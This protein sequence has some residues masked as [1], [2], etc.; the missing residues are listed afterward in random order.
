VL[1]V[2]PKSLSML[3]AGTMPMVALTSYESLSWA[4]GGAA[5]G[6]NITVLVLGGSGGTGHM[7]IQL[8]KAMGASRVITTC[9]GAHAD[10]VRG[11]GADQVID[12]HKANYYDVLPKMSIDVV[13]D[14]VGQAGTGDRAF[15][16]LKEK[17][18]F[19][20]L[21]RPGL[22]SWSTRLKR[23]DVHEYAP[24]CIGKCSQYDRTDKI[25]A[26]VELGK[27]RVHID[28]TYSLEDVEKAY[29]HSIAGHT[30][31]K[32]AIQIVKEPKGLEATA[33]IV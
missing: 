14:C 16:L 9:S 29:N 33:Y 11:L 20:T 19:I 12:Y 27:L 1:G 31:G 5:F 8:A 17:G 18:R 3:E 30:T 23:P 21:L 22:S 25:A 28:T 4:A 24:V 15:G 6:R 32:V 26:L 2:K 10:F 13:Y 7:G